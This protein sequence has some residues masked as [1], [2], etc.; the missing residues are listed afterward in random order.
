MMKGRKTF[1]GDLTVPINSSVRL[2]A[3]DT[4]LYMV[5]DSPQHAVIAL[6][7]DLGSISNWADTWLVDFNQIV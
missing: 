3:D 6:N 4:V 5:V 7:S 2:F 1:N